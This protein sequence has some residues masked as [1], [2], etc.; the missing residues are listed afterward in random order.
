MRF[1]FIDEAGTSATEPV[2][3]VVGLIVNADTQ[4]MSAEAAVAEVLGAV[5]ARFKKDFVFHAT[6]IWNSRKYRDGWSTSDRLALLHSMMRLPRRLGISISM[7]MVRRDWKPTSELKGFSRAQCHH[8]HAFCACVSRADKYIR[9]HADPREVGAVVAEDV[10]DMRT[11]LKLVPKILRENPTNLLQDQVIPTK[12]ERDAG[13]ITQ[14]TD[15][16]VT[17]IR[18]SVHF[19]EKQND[20]MLPLADACAFGLRRYFSELDTGKDFVRSILGAEPELS[21]FAGPTSLI[22]WKH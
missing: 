16:R 12:A 17:R 11:L 8:F 14:Q 6:D 4:L 18:D 7:G 1:V 5:P 2:T 21:D 22:T 9:D 20:P 13:Y 3:V 10:P 15:T 19:V